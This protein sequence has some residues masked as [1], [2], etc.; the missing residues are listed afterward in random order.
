[1]REDELM[2]GD[3]VRKIEKGGHSIPAKIVALYQDNLDCIT[4][5]GIV[6]TISYEGIEP[7]LLTPSILE[8]NGLELDSTGS[9]FDEDKSFLLEISFYKNEIIWSINV[10]E[11]DILKLEY[12]HELQ[13]AMKLCK[14]EKEIVL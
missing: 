1:M 10:N 9:Y 2:I 5:D 14:I 7:Y 6:R 4:G 8:R 12:V 3:W 11:Y 13:H